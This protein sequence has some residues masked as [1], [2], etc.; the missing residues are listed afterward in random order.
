M[1]SALAVV[2]A[3]LSVAKGVKTIEKVSLFLVPVLLFIIGFTFV[4]SLTREY[5]DLGITYLFTP[6]W[7]KYTKPIIIVHCDLHLG[8]VP[9]LLVRSYLGAP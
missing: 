2:M 6:N 8:C 3:G 7:G 5:A 9:S 1:T 4:W